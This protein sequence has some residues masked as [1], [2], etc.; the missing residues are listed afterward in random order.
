MTTIHILD[1]DVESIKKYIALGR[2]KFNF[3]I[4]IEK[5]TNSTP[6]R[7]YKPLS[8][9]LDK[10]LR[11]LKA[12]NIQRANKLNKARKELYSPNLSLKCNFS[13]KKLYLIFSYIAT[14]WWKTS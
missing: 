11:S 3:T 8:S 7:E 10:K 13:S 5:D 1:N 9:S 12:T 2:K 14:F 4:N 6:K